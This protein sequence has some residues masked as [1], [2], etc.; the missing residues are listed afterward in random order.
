MVNVTLTFVKRISI[1]RTTNIPLNIMNMEGNAV[2]KKIIKIG[3]I[4][5]ELFT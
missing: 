1:N 5:K 2:S 4:L 3:K